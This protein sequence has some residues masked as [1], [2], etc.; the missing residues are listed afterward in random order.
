MP[1]PGEWVG[2]VNKAS[3]GNLSKLSLVSTGFKVYRASSVYLLPPERLH[4]V[5]C[6]RGILQM[7]GAGSDLAELVIV[8][9]HLLHFAILWLPVPG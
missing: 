7:G 3:C 2:R 8:S 4:N 1:S 5:D 9:L 6:A